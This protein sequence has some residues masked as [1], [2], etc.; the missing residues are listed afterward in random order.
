MDTPDSVPTE[1]LPP[2]EAT[3][4]P[5]LSG[6]VPAQ[7]V[8][9]GDT[10]VVDVRSYF[11]GIIQGWAVETSS[12]GIVAAAMNA[13]GRVEL[14]GVTAGTATVTVTA[15]NNLGE[16][17]Q[18]FNATAGTRTGTTTT[19]TT[20][21]TAAQNGSTGILLTVGPNPSIQVGV[22]QS[23]TLDLSQHFTA[24]A[25]RFS[26]TGV[27]TGVQVNVSGSVATITGVSPGDYTITLVGSS[28]NA[29]ISKPARIQV[30]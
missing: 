24:A 5:T 12:P 14:R 30:T 29:S 3:A 1:S 11:E 28:A 6:S 15:L 25:T 19:T 26:V 7:T 23:T 4:A 16:V 2:V 13:A 27:P 9:I 10:L 21:T 17:A 18:A 20:T 8:G 22:S